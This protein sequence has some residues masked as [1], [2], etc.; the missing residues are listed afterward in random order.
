M[1]E[2]A[3][4]VSFVFVDK[5]GSY[6]PKA[7]KK[8]MK[9]AAIGPLSELTRRLESLPKWNLEAIEKAFNSILDAFDIKMGKLAQPIRVALTGTGTSPGIYETLHMLGREKTLSRLQAGVLYLEEKANPV[10]EV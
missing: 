10:S 1:V 6:E 3:A 9:V 5:I 8:H 2:M 7:A 4:K